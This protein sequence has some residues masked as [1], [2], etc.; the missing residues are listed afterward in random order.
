MYI[1]LK[2][3]KEKREK[4][5]L[6]ENTMTPLSNHHIDHNHKDHVDKATSQDK[7]VSIIAVGN[8]VVGKSLFLNILI[9]D[10]AFK[11]GITIG[12]GRSILFLEN[13]FETDR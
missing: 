4:I 8:P 1:E 11:S 12:K 13:S 10:H 5:G 3:G 7:G 6:D 9:G 2:K